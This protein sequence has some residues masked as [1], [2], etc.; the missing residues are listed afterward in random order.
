MGDIYDIVCVDC[1]IKLCI[2]QKHSSG[3]KLYYSNVVIMNKLRALLFSHEDH[4]LKFVRFDKDPYIDYEE[5]DFTDYF[6]EEELD[7]NFLKSLLK[8]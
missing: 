5:G 8:G 1:Q 4:I 2:G 7:R 3:D 6:K